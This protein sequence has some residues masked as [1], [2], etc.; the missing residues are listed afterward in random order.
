MRKL[1]S[2]DSDSIR[3]YRQAVRRADSKWFRWR[4]AAHGIVAR[5]VRMLELEPLY[6]PSEVGSNAGDDEDERARMER[7]IAEAEEEERKERKRK[8]VMT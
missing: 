5:V 8:P 7:E 1:Y 4:V 2:L 6:E 3:Q